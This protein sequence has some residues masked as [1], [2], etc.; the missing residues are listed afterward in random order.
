MEHVQIK[1]GDDAVF[2]ECVHNALPEGGD[3]MM[4]TKDN[5]TKGGRP[6]VCLTFTVQLPGGTLARA[7]TVVTGRN[8]ALMAAAF[9]GRYGSEGDCVSTANIVN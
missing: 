7:Q 5:A 2:D 8:F 9:R 3:L 6:A 4:V 1:L